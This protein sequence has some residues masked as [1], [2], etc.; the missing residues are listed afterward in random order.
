MS[1]HDPLADLTQTIGRTVEQ[2]GLDRML[3]WE[4]DQGRRAEDTHSIAVN[5]RG[6][7][8]NQQH[9]ACAR[10]VRHEFGTVLVLGDDKNVEPASQVTFVF[11]ISFS[12]AM[13]QLS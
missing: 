6:V 9:S 5:V 7:A 13:L 11:G 3:N 4:S 1:N 12:T 8:S 10:I 2:L